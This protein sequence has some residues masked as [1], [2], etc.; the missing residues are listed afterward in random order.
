[1]ADRSQTKPAAWAE[2][3]DFN[4]QQSVADHTISIE[5]TEGRR[6]T[7]MGSGW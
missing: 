7:N 6:H 2:K 5:R 1:M 3:Q 4:T